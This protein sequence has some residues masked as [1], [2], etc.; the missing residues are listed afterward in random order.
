MLMPQDVV[1]QLLLRSKSF[2]TGFTSEWLLVTVHKLML[3]QVPFVPESLVAGFT[4]K[5]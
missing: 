1:S 5:Q 4:F 3:L 2:A